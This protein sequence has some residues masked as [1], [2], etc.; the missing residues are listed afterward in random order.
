M[1]RILE[2]GNFAFTAADRK[3]T[4]SGIPAFSVRK[5]VAVVNLTRHAVVYSFDKPTLG[6]A[7]SDANSIT[8]AY[9]TAQHQDADVLAIVYADAGDAATATGQASALERLTSVL[10]A[11]LS[12][13]PATRVFEIAANANADLPVSTRAIRCEIGGTLVVDTVAGGTNV[14][15]RFKDGETRPVQVKRV[16]SL[17]TAQGVEGMA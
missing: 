3:I 10:E 9:D 17:G 8:L 5:V 4:F 12:Q 1:P 13:A 11:S 14:S 16:R 15:L 2:P 7:K 6:F